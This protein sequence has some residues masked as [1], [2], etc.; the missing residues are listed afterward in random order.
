M[1]NKRIVSLF[2][3]LF[4]IP[5]F[6]TGCDLKSIF[7]ENTQPIVG[8]KGEK[9]DDGEKGDTGEIGEPG[10][11]GEA[12]KD[13]CSVISNHG[14]P[15]NELGKSGDEYIDL[16]TWDYYVKDENGWHKQGN[17]KGGDGEPGDVGISIVS[18][19]I[20]ENG[21]LIVTLSNNETINVGHL[22]NVNE[23]TVNFYC[24]DLLVATQ[25]VKHGEKLVEPEL[26]DF[27]VNHWYID[28][29]LE[30]EWLLYGCVVT[31]NMSLYGK[32]VPVIKSVRFDRN[33]N[34]EI[35]E[36]G[37]GE[38]L[39]DEKEICVS[40]AIETANYLTTLDNRGILF[41]KE[42]IGPI[43]SLEINIDETNFVS[44]FVYFG[45]T[46]LS[47]DFVFEL[48]AGD[49][50]V[51]L[52]GA[53]YFTIQ[54]PENN[55]INVNSLEIHYAIQ[56]KFYDESLPTVVI[57]TKDSAPVISTLAYVD[58]N[59]ST[60]GATKD[61]ENLKGK[62][63]V[64][65][66]TTSYS[67]KKP[68]R[69]KLDKK[70]SLFGYE[71]AKNWVLLADFLDGSNMH[72]YTA[73]KFAKMLRGEDTFGVDPFH[74]NVI[75]NGENAGIY[76]FGEHIDA[77]EGRLN[78]EQDNIWEKDFDEINFYIERDLSTAQDSNETE[79]VTYF[80]VQMENY[81]PSQ[82]VFALKYPE[83]ED[84][85]EELEGG[86]VD[87]HE[88]EFNSY[89]SNLQEY[90]TNICNKFIS[91]S[92]DSTLFQSLSN[93]VDM[94]SLALFS[95]IDQA[96]TERDHGQKSFKMY[97]ANGGALKFGPNWDYDSCCYGL[98]IIWRDNQGF[99]VEKPFKVGSQTFCSTYFGEGWG[100]SLFNDLE[101]GRTLFKNIWDSIS[102]ERIDEFLISQ[103]NEMKSI[104][105]L[106]IEDCRIWMNNQFYSLFDNQRYYWKYIST[107]LPYL[108]NYYS[109]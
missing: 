6:L 15:T 63:K 75:L 64:R 43:E 88:N 25:S 57:N 5:A 20:N 105:Q 7:S 96:F 8:E 54:N 36:Y 37:Y 44:A 46:P 62:I 26:E 109:N 102:S 48:N 92:N 9:G 94:E 34:I 56:T 59:V 69:I 65:G 51:N 41:N 81:T 29:E 72:N 32:Y 86:G 18:A 55:P 35:V 71:K 40:N 99:F 2:I 42:Q 95:V 50:V 85:E 68:Y 90:M 49:N 78:I 66:N 74:V 45:K 16:D 47:F 104:A 58:C 31:E 89:I 101:N 23:Y 61:V 10:E 13:G 82:Y 33:T 87:K 3:T 108:K 93:D 70:N 19:N 11:N 28:K 53:E 1:K 73:L 83:K 77:K 38:T 4:A 91:Y 27:I 97:R 17:I 12:G 76:L 67:I 103:Q 24:D 22:I 84:F 52:S 79:G 39:K 106:S 100:N 98:P 14:E 60:L 21:D 80:R 107:Q 30:H